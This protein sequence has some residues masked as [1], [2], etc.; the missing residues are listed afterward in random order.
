MLNYEYPP[1]GGGGGV[2]FSHIAAELAKKHEIDIITTGMKGLPE[3]EEQDGVKIYRVRVMG[4]ADKATATLLSLLSFPLSSML[5]GIKLCRRKKYDVINTHFAVPTG[6]TG[7]VLSKL[8]GI[9]DILSIHGGDIYDPSKTLSPHR[10]F[11]LRKMVAYVLNHSTYVLAQST[12]VRARAIEH[13]HVKREIKI[14]PWGLK[15]PRFERTGRKQLGLDT[16]DFIIIAIG[17]LVKRKGLDHLLIAVARSLIPSIKV[18]II[19]DGPEKENLK[20]LA[21]ESGIGSR[22]TLC[23][24]VPEEQKFQYLSASDIFV[25]P[26]LHEGFGIVF[27]EAMYCGLPI[28]T[29][30]T[31]GQ[32]D[33]II[34][35]H[36]GFL[37]HVGDVETLAVKIEELYTNHDLRK[38]MAANNLEDIKKFS[39]STTAQR[40]EEMFELAKRG[41]GKNIDPAVREP[42]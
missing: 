7:L 8:F 27:L 11:L 32:T 42:S 16:G 30:D 23:G 34:D 33:F 13:Y 36:N 21:E 20:S 35:G 26:S 2:T 3:F 39:I 6:P 14:I 9:P 15:E 4:R 19:G 18:L 1:L 38:S 5:K 29:T 22:V 24:S 31:G 41:T 12:D 17:R 37:V 25:L 40:Y 28:I 10:N